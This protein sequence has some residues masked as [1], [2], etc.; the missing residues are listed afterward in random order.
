M[1]VEAKEDAVEPQIG[2]AFADDEAKAVGGPHQ[3]GHQ[4]GGGDKGEGMGNPSRRCFSGGGGGDEGVGGSGVV[5][6]VAMK[7]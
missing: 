4:V 5:L 6:A 7:V 3:W 1:M 2:E